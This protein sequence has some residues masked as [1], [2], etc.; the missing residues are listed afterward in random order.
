MTTTNFLS[1]ELGGTSESNRVLAKNK[2]PEPPP[3]LAYRIND[4][5]KAVGIGR[6]TIYKLIAEGKIRPIK[7]AGRVL[8]PANEIARLLLEAGAPK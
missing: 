6:T 4:L 8:V 1:T 7:I 2:K 5:A 3:A